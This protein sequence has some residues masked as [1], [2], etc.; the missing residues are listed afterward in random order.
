MGS[1]ALLFFGLGC[2]YLITTRP[3]QMELRTREKPLE[4]QLELQQVANEVRTLVQ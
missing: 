1:L 2:V 4:I 3:E